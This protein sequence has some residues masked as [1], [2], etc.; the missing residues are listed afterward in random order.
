MFSG[1]KDST[2]CLMLTL[3]VAARRGRLPLDV[4]F[5]DE[6][7][8]PLQTEEY[9]RRT[10]LRDDVN[11]RWYCIPL[12]HRNACSRR[13]PWWWPWAPED[14]A[15]WVR[16]LPP[17]SITRLRGFPITPP[18][19][20]MTAPDANGLFYPP[21]EY[22]QVGMVMGIR[23]QESLTRQR[24]VTKKRFENY[25]IPYTG[26]TS[27]GNVVKA[28]PVYDWREEDVW[29]APA[30]MDWDYNKGYDALE[31]AGVAKSVQRCS[32]AYGE[33]P[34]QKLWSFSHAFPEV[35]DRMCERVPG[36]ATAARYALTELYA[37]HGRPERPPDMPWEDFL[38]SYIAQFRPD[39]QKIIVKRLQD[40]I[41]R[42]YAKT[43][44]PILEK[45][46]HPQ[47]G[48]S[49]NWLLMLAMRGDF[50]KRKQPGGRI[51][52]A[53]MDLAIRKYNAERME[54]EV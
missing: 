44:D 23:A 11:L 14:E 46:P 39:D 40:E 42:H 16:P 5:M 36:A 8:I 33:E 25:L 17:E 4:V 29:T 49:W 22:G 2:A 24:A 13:S 26:P 51:N 19:S 43:N 50:K 32:P 27:H 15:K 18:E 20:R 48:V 45:A 37:Y 41:G 21:S 10:S 35:W 7:A 52:P 47:T 9:V 30:I 28:Y 54:A 12:K 34:L 53:Q 3:E 6:E 1:G 31:M 38:F